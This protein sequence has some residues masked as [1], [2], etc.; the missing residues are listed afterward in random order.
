MAVVRPRGASHKSAGIATTSARLGSGGAEGAEHSVKH[1]VSETGLTEG[2]LLGG[3]IRY[4]QPKTGY[5]TGI[6]PIFLAAAVPAHAGNQVLEAGTGA[7][8]GLL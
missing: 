4:G 7:G 2:T 3:A 8:A 5:R 1:G 6:E